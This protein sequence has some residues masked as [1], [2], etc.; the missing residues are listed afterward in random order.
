MQCYFHVILTQLATISDVGP[1]F[2]LG[3]AKLN[4]TIWHHYEKLRMDLYIIELYIRSGRWN[5]VDLGIVVL[6]I[7]SFALRFSLPLETFQMARIFFAVTLIV[8]YFRLLRFWD[9]QSELGPRIIAIQMMVR[10]EVHLFFPIQSYL[11]N[12]QRQFYLGS[13]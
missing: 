8:C 2:D 6:F 9:V 10:S 1:T 12:R 4:N 13:L 5:S 3:D 11:L 7:V